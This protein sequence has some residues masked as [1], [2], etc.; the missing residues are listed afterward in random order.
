MPKKV[1]SK[2]TNDSIPDTKDLTKKSFLESGGKSTFELTLAA[3]AVLKLI[4]G[5]INSKSNQHINA[6]GIRNK[7]DYVSEAIIQF[8]KKIIE[9]DKLGYEINNRKF[10]IETDV[11][12]KRIELLEKAVASL[13]MYTIED[14][15]ELK[16]M[17]NHLINTTKNIKNKNTEK[18]YDSFSENDVFFNTTI[19]KPLW[20]IFIYA[21][22]HKMLIK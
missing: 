5:E 8:S 16:K 11:T 7:K 10:D 17:K 21:L 4:E 20:L 14:N 6:I 3:Q 13:G 19:E 9:K 12:I 18:L 2:K 15:N 1:H 22:K